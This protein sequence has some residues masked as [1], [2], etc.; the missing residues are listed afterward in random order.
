FPL[1]FFSAA[2]GAELL[3][4]VG[5]IKGN[6]DRPVTVGGKRV[7]VQ[8]KNALIFFIESAPLNGVVIEALL[9]PPPAPTRALAFAIANAVLR[10][11]PAATLL[12]VAAYDGVQSPNG[13]AVI[14]FGLQYLL[15]I[16]PDP[17]AANISVPYDKLRDS[18][19]SGA[20]NAFVLWSQANAPVLTYTLPASALTATTAGVAP[21]AA[22]KN[23]ELTAA[24]AAAIST[25][26]GALIL[27]DLS[28]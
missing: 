8:S 2:A 19:T 12:L 16:L 23:T 26:P 3:V 6:F 13:A 1:R 20:L 17:Y 4:L 14:G 24:P 22:T 28:T 10:T 9:D 5:S 11:T 18:R 15:P 7:F 25:Q 21:F 27:L